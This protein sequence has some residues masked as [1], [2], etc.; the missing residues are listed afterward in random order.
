M[1]KWLES[2]SMALLSLNN[3][4][5]QYIIY[6]YYTCYKKN[7]KLILNHKYSPSLIIFIFIF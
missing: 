4:K 7:I 5:N 3:H 6:V 1:A 2:Y